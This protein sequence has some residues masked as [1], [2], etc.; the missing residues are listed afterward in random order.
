[1][2]DEGCGHTQP[3]DT[4]S[5]GSVSLVVGASRTPVPLVGSPASLLVAVDRGRVAL[6]PY[7]LHPGVA[8]EPPA[9]ASVQVWT[10]A[11]GAPPV[12]IALSSP[13]TAV[14]L[15]RS[16]VAVLVDGRLERYD[17]ATGASLGSSSALAGASTLLAARGGTFV[18]AGTRAIAAVNAA[19]GASHVVVHTRR[20]PGTIAVGAGRVLWSITSARGSSIHVAR[21][22]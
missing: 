5:S 12:T 2:P 7:A 16:V 19:T 21:L 8:G 18:Y 13:P 1:M 6:V 10:I 11:S 4:I 22:G 20:R 14:A 15:T 3:G 17:A 9:A